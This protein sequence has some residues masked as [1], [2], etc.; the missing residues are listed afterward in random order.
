ME[1]LPTNILVK[2]FEN[3]PSQELIA[4]SCTCKKFLEITK[5][6]L[7][8]K[9]PPIRIDFQNLYYNKQNKFTY[10][11]GK[12]F[13]VLIETTRLHQNFVLVNF[14]KEH[15]DRLNGKW[16][17][18]FKTQINAR[19]IRIKSDCMNLQEFIEL[20]KL[21]QR[22]ILLEVDG[23]R[24]VDDNVSSTSYAL[25]PSLKHL[26]LHS[27]LDMTPKFFEVL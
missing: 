10:R 4:L 16:L 13:N 24:L 21:T 7:G 15:T 12:D 5:D 20:I 11:D 23:Y 14:N 6:F 27:F 19:T 22:L 2:I 1:Q 25:L 17:K 9:F 8:I 18:L 3:L 26:K